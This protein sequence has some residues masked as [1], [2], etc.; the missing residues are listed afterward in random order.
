MSKHIFRLFVFMPLVACLVVWHLLTSD[1]WLPTLSVGVLLYFPVIQFGQSSGYHKLFAHNSFEPVA[2]YPALA[3]LIASISFFGDPLAS[4]MAHRLHHKY[5]G[6]DKD[7]H[8]PQHGVFHAYIGW[9]AKWKPSTADTRVIADL[10]RKYPWM[11]TYRKYELL[12]PI[13][14]HTTMFFFAGWLFYPVALACVLAVNNGLLVNALS[15]DHIT[16][17]AADLKILARFINPIFLHKRHHNGDG[18]GVDYSADGVVDVWGKLTFFLFAKRH[19][20]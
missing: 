16:G 8:N 19:A 12:V 3:T 5:S 1:L 6:G 9:I 7:P 10:V 14:F 20:P 4:A 15:H 13:L 11:T 18:R 17:D 2:W